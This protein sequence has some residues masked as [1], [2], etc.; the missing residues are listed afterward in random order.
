M[1]DPVRVAVEL[2]AAERELDRADAHRWATLWGSAGSALHGDLRQRCARELERR[3]SA[4]R[5][6]RDAVARDVDAQRAV[7]A[8]GEAAAQGRAQLAACALGRPARRREVRGCRS[9]V[10][11]ARADAQVERAHAGE[12]LHR[13]VERQRAREPRRVPAQLQY[14]LRIRRRGVEREPAHVALRDAQR[15]RRSGRDRSVVEAQQHVFDPQRVDPYDGGRRGGTCRSGRGGVVRVCAAPICAGQ[16]RKTRGD[17][18]AIG[19]PRRAAAQPADEGLGQ[20]DPV[21]RQMGELQRDAVERERLFAIDA[22]PRAFERERAARG[23]GLRR[24]PR[25]RRAQREAGVDL[26]GQGLD[27]DGAQHPGQRLRLE[28]AERDVQGRIEQALA[29][30]Q[31]AFD[32]EPVEQR[33]GARVDEEARRRVRR[34]DVGQA[35]I[36]EQHRIERRLRGAVD[37]LDAHVLQPR[38]IDAQR[39]AEVEGARA[40]GRGRCRRSRGCV[41]ASRPRVGRP[42]IGEQPREL[43]TA[44]ALALEAHGDTVDGSAAHPHRAPHEGAHVDIQIDVFDRQQVRRLC[45]GRI[46]RAARERPHDEPA[47]PHVA[48]QQRERQVVVAHVE[49]LCSPQ[50]R[51]KP[52]QRKRRGDAHERDEH[53]RRDREPLRPTPQR[54]RAA[55]QTSGAG[56]CCAH[57]ATPSRAARSAARRA[58]ALPSAS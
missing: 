8:L 33:V 38:R 31:R 47:Q 37:E 15:Q 50:A 53:D 9:A 7:G 57:G 2:R 25:H 18:R 4:A 28:S 12:G 30:A 1:Y 45:G 26:L 24:V 14:D 36:T 22:E 41:G 17:E 32:A 35:H 58:S 16:Q 55:P 54:A 39:R 6:E 40:L 51:E 10:E 43:P 11:R 29:A 27:A 49:A 23:A 21:Q 5:C 3:P 48:F 44:V 56:G 46:G 34:A 13:R 52:R 19:P 42:R 20:L